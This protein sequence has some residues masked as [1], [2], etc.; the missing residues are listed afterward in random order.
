MDLAVAHDLHDL[1]LDRLAD[2]RQFFRPTVER[3]LG[4]RGARLEDARGGL[5]VGPDPERVARFEFH[6]VG[7]KLELR[8]EH[9][10]PG[11][12]RRVAAGRGHA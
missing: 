5:A 12:A 10:V 9:G 6:Q 1:L 2:A 4:D 3:K 8:G 11:H 7:E